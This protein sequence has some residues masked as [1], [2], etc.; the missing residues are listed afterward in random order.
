MHS[1]VY[2]HVCLCVLL[3]S[4]LWQS[5]QQNVN[6]RKKGFILPHS[7]RSQ[8]IKVRKAAGTWG[9]WSHCNHSQGEKRVIA[10]YCSA[11][12]LHFTVQDPSLGNGATHSGQVFLP[13][14]MQQEGSES[15]LNPHRCPQ[16]PTGDPR[17]C[18]LTRSVNS[19]IMTFKHNTIYISIPKVKYLGMNLKICEQDLQNSDRRNQC[20][21]QHAW[22]LT[23]KE[24]KRNLIF[25]FAIVG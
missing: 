16:P 3:I 23:H 24:D 22:P 5:T 13:H 11:P 19:W 21:P 12:F 2:V 14:W 17:F 6:L 8:S 7:S 15:Y 10:C 4:L 18:Q 25:N 1:C 20:V 9:S